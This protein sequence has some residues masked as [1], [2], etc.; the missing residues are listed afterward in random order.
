[1]TW[2]KLLAARFLGTFLMLGA[3][4]DFRAVEPSSPAEDPRAWVVPPSGVSLRDL[5]S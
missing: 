5:G 3:V 4:E 1:V 2:F